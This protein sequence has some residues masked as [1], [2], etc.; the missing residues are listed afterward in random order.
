MNRVFCY[1]VNLTCVVLFLAFTVP[2]CVFGFFIFG[3][4]YVSVYI[5]SVCGCFVFVV[6]DRWDNSF[7][8]LPKIWCQKKPVVTNG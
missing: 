8:M 7:E 6:I 5:I 1:D 4:I 3:E 2:I